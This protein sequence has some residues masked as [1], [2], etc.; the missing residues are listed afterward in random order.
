MRPKLNAEQLCKALD[1]QLQGLTHAEIAAKIDVS[2]VTV[3]RA[4]AKH[5]RR[6][7]E[8]LM[9]RALEFKAKQVRQ[10]EYLYSESV[11]EW[12][13]SKLDSESTKT[14]EGIGEIGDRT[15]VTIRGQTGNPAIL[16]QARGTLSDI[17]GILGIDA[18]RTSDVTSG[19]KALN[20]G[21]LDLAKLSM[22]ELLILRQMFDRT[23]PEGQED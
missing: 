11:S 2:R 17:R 21:Q 9:R 3:Q 23:T 1:L 6:V 22:N 7:G 18:P 5:N 13:R 16:A 19:G 10:L 4:L 15:E 20:Q 14:T 12:H 8:K